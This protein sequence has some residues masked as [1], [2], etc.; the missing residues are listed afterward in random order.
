MPLTPTDPFEL[1]KA[2]WT[3]ED[4]DQ[5]G[6]HDV[7]IHAIAFSTVTHE[8]LLDIDYMFAWVDPEAPEVHYTFWMA[9][10]TL[11]FANVHSFAA[12]IE[13]GLGLEVSHVEREDAGRPKNADY[14]KREKE[15]KWTFNCQEG[16]FSFHAVGYQQ[17]TRSRPVRAKSQ[18]F[19]WEGR[20]GVSFARC[21]YDQTDS[22]QARMVVPTSASVFNASPPFNLNPAINAGPR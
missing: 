14:I 21:P 13:T 10:C 5:M 9:P 17:I 15:W 11:V 7:H 6:W 3:E 2:I 12:E 16:V 8:L 19:E 1:E 22:E 20:G 4:F 18:S